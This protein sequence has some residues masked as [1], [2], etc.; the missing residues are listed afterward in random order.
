[1]KRRE[2]R[3]KQNIEKHRNRDKNSKL[4]IRRKKRKSNKSDRW[5]GKK[6]KEK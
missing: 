3:I 4:D 5:E 6:M 2:R 1:M